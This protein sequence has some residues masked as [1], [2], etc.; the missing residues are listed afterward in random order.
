MTWELVGGHFSPS[1]LPKKAW[2]RPPCLHGSVLVALGEISDGNKSVLQSNL[3][4]VTVTDLRRQ[5]C[6]DLNTTQR[7]HQRKP[8]RGLRELQGRKAETYEEVTAR[9]LFHSISAP[10]HGLFEKM[11]RYLSLHP[12]V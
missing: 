12:R 2:Y 5:I 1:P 11:G 8:P 6:L 3:D 7:E 10:S 4:P 9:G